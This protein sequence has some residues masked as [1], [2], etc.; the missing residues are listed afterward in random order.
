MSWSNI[1]AGHF[2]SK[3]RG[4]NMVCVAGKMC[5]GGWV[6]VCVCV[7]V[8]LLWLVFLKDCEGYDFHI[9]RVDVG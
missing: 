5:V 9:W 2:R 3:V 7:C 1:G 4:Q 6:G 8:R